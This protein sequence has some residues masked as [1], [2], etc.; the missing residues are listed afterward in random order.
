MGLTKEQAS[1]MR[2]HALGVLAFVMLAAGGA[3]Y[4]WPPSD[5]AV[6][7][8]N[9]VCVRVGLVFMAL[10]LALPQISRFPPWLYGTTLVGVIIVVRYPRLI[11]AVVPILFLLWMIKPKPRPNTASKRK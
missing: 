1:N 6:N 4:V 8:L 10:W 2:R 3:M 7:S 11:V 5:A 9:G